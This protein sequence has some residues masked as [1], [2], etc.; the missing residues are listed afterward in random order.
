[1]QPMDE[2]LRA[3]GQYGPKVPVPGDAPAVDRL[4][5]FLGR[6]PSRPA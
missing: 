2:F 6:D 5:G 1:M 4:M 3:S